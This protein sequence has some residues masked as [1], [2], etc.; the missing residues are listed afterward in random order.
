MFGESNVVDFFSFQALSL[1]VWL[2]YGIVILILLVI[3]HKAHIS[4]F[5]WFIRMNVKMF[6]LVS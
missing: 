1:S 6:M 5:M 3:D 2:C 4:V